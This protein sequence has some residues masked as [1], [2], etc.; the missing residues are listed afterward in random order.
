MSEK[1]ENCIIFYNCEQF[2]N[3]K[4]IGSD[5]FCSVNNLF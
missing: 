1:Q 5:Y 3:D 4:L 2:F